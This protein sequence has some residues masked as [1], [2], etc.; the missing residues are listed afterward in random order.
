MTNLYSTLAERFDFRLD[1][2]FLRVPGG[3]SLTYREVD[4]RSA[5]M[6]TVLRDLGVGVGDR[7][8]LQ[9]DKS[10]DNVALYL[11]CLRIGAV[12]LPLNTAY[13]PGEVGFFVDDAAPTVVVARP[14]TLD[15]LPTRVVHLDTDGTG[16]FA[17]AAD[18][19]DAGGPVVGRA[20]GAG[21][22]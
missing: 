3:G 10:T 5:R 13:T 11:A 15:D 21:G 12:F 9:I 7:V 4:Q 16:S 2:T 17:E 20:P 18:V 19:A 14:G 22:A 1:A 6:A 8:V